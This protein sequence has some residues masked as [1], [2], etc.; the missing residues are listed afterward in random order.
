[1]IDTEGT[2][3]RFVRIV[4]EAMGKALRRRVLGQNEKTSPFGIGDDRRYGRDGR[5][6]G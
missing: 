4:F 3:N 5:R 2:E 6:H 1:M